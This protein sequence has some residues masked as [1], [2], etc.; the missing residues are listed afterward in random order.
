LG[1]ASRRRITKEEIAF[2]TL[3]PDV[4]WAHKNVIFEWV[5]VIPEPSKEEAP[6]G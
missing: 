3:P 1:A 6:D 4:I 5:P 2:L